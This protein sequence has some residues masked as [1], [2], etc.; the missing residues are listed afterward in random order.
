MPSSLLMSMRICTR[1]LILIVGPLVFPFACYSAFV[2]LFPRSSTSELPVEVTLIHNPDAGDGE[3]PAADELV[4]LVR[5]AGHEV[6]YQSVKERNWHTILEK[7]ADV[8]AAAG[9]DGTVGKVVRRLVGRH[10][11][12]AVLPTGTANN[13]SRALGLTDMPIE[14][15]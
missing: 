5:G 11:P 6:L 2:R 12:V 4:A 14:R 7:P 15:L 3:K 9:G 10:I 8:V 13:I 1:L